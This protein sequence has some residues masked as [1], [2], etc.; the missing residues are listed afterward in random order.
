MAQNQNVCFKK[1]IQNICFASSAQKRKKTDKHEDEIFQYTKQ[2]P[3][4][5]K[6]I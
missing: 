6:Q 1:K 5:K 3:D 4:K 2:I